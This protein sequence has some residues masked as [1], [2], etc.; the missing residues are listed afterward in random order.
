DKV[1]KELPDAI[2][3]VTDDTAHTPEVYDLSGRKMSELPAREGIYIYNGKK[4]L[5]P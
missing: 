2:H 4:I 5:I 1:I 3:S